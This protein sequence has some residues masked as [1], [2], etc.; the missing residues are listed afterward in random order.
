MRTLFSAMQSAWDFFALFGFVVLL[1]LI[2]ASS[3]PLPSI[4][5][6]QDIGVMLDA[7]WRYFQGQQCHVD[8]RS[9]LGP[10]FAMLPG[11]PFSLFGPEYSSLRYL[12]LFV[13]SVLGV[14]VLA[15]TRSVI[16]KP[17]SLVTSVAIGLFG[18]GLFH[19]GFAY[20]ALTFATFYNRVAFGLLCISA[21]ACLIPRRKLTGRKAFCFDLSLGVALSLLLFL[22]I[23]FFA[24][25]ALLAVAS[26][27]VNRRS[28][29][30]L[31]VTGAGFAICSSLIASSFGF[32]FDLMLSDILM[33][34][35]AREGVTYTLFFYPMRNFLAN[36]DYFAL[37]A[38]LSIV[39][40][41]E[42]FQG[43]EH[44]KTCLIALLVYWMPALIGF[45]IT[46]M[47]S[48]GDGRCFPTLIVGGL[49]ASAWLATESSVRPL[50]RNVVAASVFLQAALVIVPHIAA[51]QFLSQ[52]RKENFEGAF[53]SK[54][55]SDWR[56]GPFNNYGPDFI[57]LINEGMALVSAN[58][59]KSA[60][61]QYA[62]FANNFNFGLGLRS[63]RGSMLWWDNGSTYSAK[64][65]PSIDVFR[66]TD[67]ILIPTTRPIQPLDTWM[68]VYARH[69]NAFYEE[70]A[71]SPNFVLL[72]KKQ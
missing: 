7:G 35:A 51:Y 14:W 5:C 56:I 66:D 36:T 11:I 70:A 46:L 30:S 64:S 41:I 9:P 57:P 59:P 44:R 10:V 71:R 2:L 3:I 62:D 39:L 63:P 53:A 33:A 18:G 22:K 45:A 43:S 68:S 61:L 29:K 69:L 65:H 34:A 31:G 15:L 32:R 54:A 60:S 12:P 20:Q 58:A 28:W 23:N 25:G 72:R 6:A 1:G 50:V 47:Q 27:L 24:F 19:P 17:L 49:A 8:Y 52:L 26:L 37:A 55:L 42:A 48:H 4:A 13:T 16:P 21:I 67:L 38:L 40:I